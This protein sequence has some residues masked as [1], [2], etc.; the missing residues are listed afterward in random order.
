MHAQA[1]SMVALPRVGSCHL[2]HRDRLM[3]RR[4]FLGSVIPLAAMSQRQKLKPRGQRGR[5]RRNGPTP[6]DGDRLRARLAEAPLSRVKRD[7]ESAEERRRRLALMEALEPFGDRK[8]E[9]LADIL[10]TSRDN[11]MCLGAAYALGELH[12]PK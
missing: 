11:V 10:R 4:D 7:K 6:E 8:V 2:H 9:V 5:S 12:D 3:R 1:R